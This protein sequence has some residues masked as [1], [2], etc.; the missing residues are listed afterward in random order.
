MSRLTTSVVS[1]LK[2]TWLLAWARMMSTGSSV[3][4]STRMSSMYERA[5][6]T[7]LVSSTDCISSSVLTAMR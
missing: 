5:G 6:M 1:T 4:P 3:S 2:M 7:T